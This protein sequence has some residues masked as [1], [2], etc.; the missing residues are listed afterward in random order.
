[1]N[2]LYE[3]DLAGARFRRLCAVRHLRGRLPLPEPGRRPPLLR[4]VNP[5]QMTVAAK[6]EFLDA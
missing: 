4:R 1:M 5:P 3:R 6:P 2:D